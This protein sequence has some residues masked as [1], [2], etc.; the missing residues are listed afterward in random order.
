M[1]L[2]AF[3]SA[4]VCLLEGGIS[5]LRTR[6]PSIFSLM[7]WKRTAASTVRDFPPSGPLS[8]VGSPMVVTDRVGLTPEW[9]VTTVESPI[10]TACRLRSEVA[11][12]GG[13]R[14]FEISSL[15]GTSKDLFGGWLGL[16]SNPCR[17][18]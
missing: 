9:P 1:R 14:D 16:E 8:T 6:K 13:F 15:V 3:E 4:I 7:K 10:L 17:R 2:C 11:T 12:E 18:L 5:P